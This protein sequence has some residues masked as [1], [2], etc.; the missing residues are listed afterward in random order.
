MILDRHAN[1]NMEE[2]V[3]EQIMVGRNEKTI[4]EY[5]KNQLKEDDMVK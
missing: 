1:L 3:F 2:E 4:K 5:M